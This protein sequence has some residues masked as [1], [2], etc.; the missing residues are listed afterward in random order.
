MPSLIIQK[1]L[2]LIHMMHKLF[3]SEVSIFPNFL[4]NAL[5]NLE[6]YEDAIINYTK[7]LEFNPHHAKAFYKR[8]IY[9][10]QFLGYALIKLERYEEAIIDYTKAIEINPQIGDA[11]F[12]RGRY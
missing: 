11:Y 6:R 10:F 12:N 2:N 4:G 3:I 5:S 7:A 1:L 9:F 8:G